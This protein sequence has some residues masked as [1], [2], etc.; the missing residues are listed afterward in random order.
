MNKTIN[1]NLAGIVF[2]IDEN[3]FHSLK[4]YLEEIRISLGNTKGKEEIIHDVESRIAELFQKEMSDNNKNVVGQTMVNEAI[5]ILGQPEDY[6]NDEEKNQTFDRSSTKSKQYFRNP[7]DKIIS[8]VCGGIAVYFSW[9]PFIVRIL[10]MLSLFLPGIFPFQIIAYIVLWI[11]VPEAITTSDKLKMRGE[12]INFASIKK[13]FS[14]ET[15]KVKATINKTKL[16]RFA[17]DITRIILLVL[18]AFVIFIGAIILITIGFSIV[19]LLLGMLGVSPFA[20]E[21]FSDLSP[22]ILE[23]KSLLYVG[24]IALIF[25]FFIPIIFLVMLAARLI[26]K[27]KVFY[28]PV[29]LSMIILWLLSIVGMTFVGVKVASYFSFA[30]SAN[31]SFEIEKQDFFNI[32]MEDTDNLHR[33]SG[34]Y[35]LFQSDDEPDKSS[36]F[37]TKLEIKKSN[38]SVPRLRV[39]MHSRG[40]NRKDANKNAQE[41]NFE[42]T[43]DG[44]DLVLDE[45][46]SLSKNKKYRAQRIELILYLPINQKFHLDSSVKDHLSNMDIV[47]DFWISE[48]ISEDLMMTEKGVRCLTC[49]QTE[50]HEY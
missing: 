28:W 47:G 44:E 36:W 35:Y 5:S 4:S 37:D 16:E 48:L 22:L 14:S 7:D 27:K 9:D 38:D 40:K 46:P 30:G 3:A 45:G 1:I 12:P 13:N 50:E 24:Y 20:F 49:K 43:Q 26:F 41:T 42:F 31:K 11:I 6:I 15:D 33:F 39:K 34:N 17:E 19:T 29:S 18:K 10:A 8:G 25:F 2:H 21:I 23:S 32:E